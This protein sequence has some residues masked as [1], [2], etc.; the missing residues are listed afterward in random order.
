MISSTWRTWKEYLTP[1]SHHSTFYNTGQ[2]TPNEF[3]QTGEYL[4]HMFPT[5]HWNQID[6]CDKLQIRDFLPN[7]NQFLI[8]RKVPCR[9]RVDDYQNNI[10][11]LQFD[12]EFITNDTP[13]F[14]SN[15]K[16][17]T[18]N[19]KLSKS[20]DEIGDIDIDMAEKLNLGDDLEDDIAN[21]EIFLPQDENLRYYDLYIGYSTSYRV[22]KFYLVGYNVEGLPLTPEQMFQDISIEYR[23]KTATI[24]K[25]P[26]FKDSVLS[27]SIHPCKHAHVMKILLDKIRTIKKQRKKTELKPGNIATSTTVPEPDNEDDWEDLQDDVD[28][29]LQIDQYLIIFLKFI[30]SITPTIEHDYTMESW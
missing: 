20:E 28:D 22:P 11:D 25:L 17:K 30:N 9:N 27:V 8:S 18:N 10:Q 7:G 26:F 19:S 14:V 1:V 16:N 24:E 15:E 4:V 3:I 21:D 29:N 13:S 23:T 6:N 12:E 2:L 5:W